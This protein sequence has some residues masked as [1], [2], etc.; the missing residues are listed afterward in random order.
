MLMIATSFC[1]AQVRSFDILDIDDG[2][3]IED[4]IVLVNKSKD[5]IDVATLYGV[6]SDD[7]PKGFV[8][9]EFISKNDDGSYTISPKAEMILTFRGLRAGKSQKMDFSKKYHVNLAKKF[10]YLILYVEEPKNFEFSITD[11]K[12]KRSDLYIYVTGYGSR[13]SGKKD[14]EK[15]VDKVESREKKVTETEPVEKK[16]QEQKI[17]EKK[18]S[19][20]KREGKSSSKKKSSSSTITLKLGEYVCSSSNDLRIKLTI[21]GTVSLKRGSK[22]LGV[23]TYEMNGNRLSITWTSLTSDGQSVVKG[24]NITATIVDETKFD[25]GDLWVYVE[26]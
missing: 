6:S 19:D 24:K 5:N 8:L 1:F 21:L 22:N 26:K 13:K 11:L 20:E 2:E 25:N 17:S 14:A 23:G 3:D 4:N 7:C 18:P 16:K 9:N 15:T 12:E 10:R